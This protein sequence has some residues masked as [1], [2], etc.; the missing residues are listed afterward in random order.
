MCFFLQ[1]IFL[2]PIVSWS[3][4]STKRDETILIFDT[5]QRSLLL[6]NSGGHEMSLITLI[7]S[8]Y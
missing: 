8:M 4:V 2:I 7:Q 3:W 1:F 5:E 6:V